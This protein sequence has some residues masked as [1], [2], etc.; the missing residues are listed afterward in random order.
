V[1]TSDSSCY[2]MAR[3]PI[4]SLKLILINYI[5]VNIVGFIILRKASLSSLAIGGRGRR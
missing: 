2:A 5:E 3:W 4:V 1:L